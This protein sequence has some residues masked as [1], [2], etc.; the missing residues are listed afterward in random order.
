MMKYLYLLLL[1]LLYI[2]VSSCSKNIKFQHPYTLEE[3]ELNGK[4]KTYSIVK[5]GNLYS[6]K[7]YKK[8]HFSLDGILRHEETNI[9]RMKI[10]IKKIYLYQ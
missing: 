6:E 9:I 5:Y 1:T 8:Y 2:S 10:I 3:F 4:V 7:E